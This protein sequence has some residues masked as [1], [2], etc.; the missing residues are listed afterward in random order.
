MFI[1]STK[2]CKAKLNYM[3]ISEFYKTQALFN[4]KDES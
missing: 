3:D 1:N 4:I 2:E